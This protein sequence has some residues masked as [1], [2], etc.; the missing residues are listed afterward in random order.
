MDPLSIIASVTAILTAAAKV[1]SVLGA[2]KEAPDSIS[3]LLIEVTYIKIVFSTLQK[4]LNRTLQ[5]SPQR[6]AFIQL[7]DIVVILTQTVLV[8]SELETFV[9]PLLAN[10]RV[11]RWQRITWTWE[12]SGV[13]RLVNQLQHHK[14]SL[15]LMLQ[16][17]QWC[18][19]SQDLL[20]LANFSSVN[21]F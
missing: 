1:A 8:F 5:F 7:D 6:A 19:V 12:Q 14:T 9:G 21:H 13:S 2:I 10:C 18:A 15:S 16:I 17:M 3:K 4:F 20:Y 11:S